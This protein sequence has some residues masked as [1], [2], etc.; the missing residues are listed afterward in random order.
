M[1]MKKTIIRQGVEG[2]SNI[3][4]NTDWVGVYPSEEGPTLFYNREVYP[5]TN[6][7][8]DVEMIIGK[9]R[10][11]FIFYWKGEMKISFRYDRNSNFF[12]WLY[13]LLTF[14]VSKTAVI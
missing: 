13:D 6:N 14:K 10:N 5:L 3:Q 2:M 8:W 4:M 1:F 12:V 11:L 7:L 9:E